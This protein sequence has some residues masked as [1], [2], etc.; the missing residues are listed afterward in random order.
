[1]ETP[2]ER[3]WEGVIAEL[4]SDVIR[5]LLTVVVTTE[6]ATDAHSCIRSVIEPLVS[7][8]SGDDAWPY[9]THCS[10]CSSSRAQR[11]YT[12]RSP[13]RFGRFSCSDAKTIQKNCSATWIEIWE[14]ASTNRSMAGT[15][16]TSF[17]STM[18]MCANC[19]R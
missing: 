3:T 17:G 11:V 18:I 15:L 16:A 9:T 7:S 10:S 19:G 6:S 2:F 13:P 14:A 12:A 4:P 8:W 5:S 1:M